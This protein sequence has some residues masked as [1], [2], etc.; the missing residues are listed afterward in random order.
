MNEKI[1]QII[2]IYI[3]LFG[4]SIWIIMC[5]MIYVAAIYGDG[6]MMVNF[7]KFG[8]MYIEIVVFTAISIFFILYCIMETKKLGDYGRK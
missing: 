7:N 3:G 5:F 1:R 6:I 4:S 8:E 2:R